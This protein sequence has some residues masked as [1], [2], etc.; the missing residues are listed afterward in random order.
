MDTAVGSE[1]FS[2]RYLA[3]A[4]TVVSPGKKM[5]TL[6]LLSLTLPQGKET[7]RG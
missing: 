1:E 2:T 4:R 7:I 6:P 5:L 3:K